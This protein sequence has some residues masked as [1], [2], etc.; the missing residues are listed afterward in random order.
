MNEGRGVFPAARVG[1]TSRH[2][3]PMKNYTFYECIIKKPV[4][5]G[6]QIIPTVTGL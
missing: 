2:K 4:K 1:G 3:K 6:I 5:D